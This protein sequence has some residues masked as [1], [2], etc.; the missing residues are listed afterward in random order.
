MPQLT[1]IVY[2]ISQLD[3]LEMPEPVIKEAISKYFELLVVDDNTSNEEF[4]ETFIDPKETNAAVEP[5]TIRGT[6]EKE[7]ENS[8]SS[9][10]KA[11][12]ERKQ[13]REAAEKQAAEMIAQGNKEREESQ[14]RRLNGEEPV[15][16]RLHM[17]PQSD[18]DALA[19]APSGGSS[20]PPKVR[21]LFDQM[22]QN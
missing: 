4:P 14:R 16:E 5:E 8:G 22:S 2:L 15:I 1:G 13:K 20:N 7:L 6:I 3:K 10:F 18:F 11:L 9:Y 17:L 19:M 21:S 12:M